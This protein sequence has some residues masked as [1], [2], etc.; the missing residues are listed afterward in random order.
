MRNPRQRDKDKRVS[1]CRRAGIARPEH[2]S[3][4]PLTGFG[5]RLR[6]HLALENRGS[7]EVGAMSVAS[8]LDTPTHG[9]ELE[10]KRQHFLERQV[11]VAE[12]GGGRKLYR[13]Q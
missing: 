9:G 7:L 6:G 2:R 11:S 10:H 3:E 1:M 13:I 8:L 5:I 4:K 12:K